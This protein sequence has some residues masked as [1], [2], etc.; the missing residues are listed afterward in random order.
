MTNTRRIA[1]RARP[2]YAAAHGTVWIDILPV[3]PRCCD[4]RT[5]GKPCNRC[6]RGPNDQPITQNRAL[7]SN[8]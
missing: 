8:A 5:P 7:A 3:F 1:D 6:G 4:T 2:E